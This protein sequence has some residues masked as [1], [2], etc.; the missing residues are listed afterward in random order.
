MM[1]T[2]PAFPAFRL[3]DGRS[4]QMESI[5]RT[6]T[7]DHLLSGSPDRLTNFEA[8]QRL[9]RLAL[10]MSSECG[11]DSKPYLLPTRVWILQSGQWEEV[12]WYRFRTYPRRPERL[13]DDLKPEWMP[14]FASAARFISDPI[15]RT[16]G[17]YSV[18]SVFWFQEGF[19]PLI[20]EG[21]LEGLL[22][23]PWD[24]TAKDLRF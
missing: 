5:Y 7:Y 2:K 12:E 16:N 19:G 9:R 6:N 4:I 21:P 23:L 10:R 22:S 3:R 14:C 24:A 11:K 20:E 1:P 13:T 18:L 8:V 17:D 15:F